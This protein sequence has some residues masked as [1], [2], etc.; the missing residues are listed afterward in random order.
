MEKC[1]QCGKTTLLP[2]RFSNM[3]L[4]GKCASLVNYSEWVERI[5][6]TKEDLAKKKEDIISLASSN[7]IN[8]EIIDAIS[9][10]FNEFTN[11]DFITSYDGR[12]GQ[13]IYIFDKY[14]IINTKNDSTRDSLADDFNSFDPKVIDLEND[15][16]DDDD[17]LL[18]ATEKLTLAKNLFSKSIVSNGIATAVTLGVKQVEKEKKEEKRENAI[19]KMREK[20]ARK[21]ASQIVV[22]DEKIYFS[23]FSKTEIMTSDDSYYE[24]IKFV[25]NGIKANDI[26]ECKYFFVN[27]S[28]LF[29][30]KEIKQK[31]MSIRDI[32]NKQ[33]KKYMVKEEKVENSQT[34]QNDIAVNSNKT[35]EKREET[36]ELDQFSE[37]RKYKELLDEGIITNEEFEK[38]KKSLLNL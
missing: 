23:D 12:S 27:T 24:L 26:Y 13:K 10:Y 11:E 33:I 31:V 19:A 22:G 7:G 14:Y 32:V 6:E 30:S 21:I 34:I 38:K 35:E 28:K 5:F 37:I 1:K 9:T 18:S 17:E 3:V 4:C 8:K 36:K 15:D 16:D 25:P 2:K 29:K 20:N